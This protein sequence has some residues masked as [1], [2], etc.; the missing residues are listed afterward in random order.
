M[1]RIDYEVSPTSRQALM[2]LAADIRNTLRIHAPY[3]PILEVVEIVLPKVQGMEDFALTI[4]DMTE[5]G[6]DHGL[7]YTDR[8]EIRLREDVY[9]GVYRGKGRDRFTL[10]HELGHLLLHANQAYQRNMRLAENIPPYKSAEWQANTFAGAL[11]MPHDYLKRTQDVFTVV[12]ECGVTVDA[13]MTH[14]R[15]LQKGGL[16]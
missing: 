11:L 6:A 9:E 7:T 5:M 4:G 10:A 8:K 3:F 13:A 12:E 1:S 15:L 2:Q 14:T 16:L